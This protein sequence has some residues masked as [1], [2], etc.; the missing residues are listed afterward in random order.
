MSSDGNVTPLNRAALQEAAAAATVMQHLL[1]VVGMASRVR[2]P[3]RIHHTA[4]DQ[5]L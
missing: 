5:R 4:P 3:Q 1:M 2:P